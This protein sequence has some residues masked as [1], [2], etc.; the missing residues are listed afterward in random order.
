MSKPILITNFTGQAENPHIGFGVNVG[1]D[2]YTT[3]NV[4]RLSRKMEKKSAALATDLPLFATEDNNGYIYSQLQDGKILKSTDDGV[5]WT[6]LAGNAGTD[7]K[8]LVAWQDYL[9]AFFGTGVDLYGPL[10]GASAWINNWTGFTGGKALQNVVSINHVPFPAPFANAFMY[11]CNGKYIAQVK[12]ITFP[13][14]PAGASNVDWETLN[15]KF[16]MQDYYNAKCLGFLPTSSIAIGVENKLNKSQADIVIWDGSADTSA[17]NIFTIPG[18]TGPVTNLLTRNG[19]MYATTTNEAGVYT[20]NGSSAQLVDRLGLRM[21]NRTSTGVQNTSRVQPTVQVGSADFLGPEM[22]VGICSYPTPVSQPAGTGLYP[23]G[24]W[25]ADIEGKNVYTKFP[26]SHG[27]INAQYTTNYQIGFVK[28][29]SNGKVLVGWQKS[30]TFG[31]DALNASDYISDP[32]TTF[33][34]SEL[35]EVGTRIEPETYNN[36]Q[37]NLIEPLQTSAQLDFY[38]RLSQGDPY[39][40]FRTETPATLGANLGGIITPLPFQQ[41]KYVQFGV[42][43]TTGSGTPTQTPQL[44]S[45]YLK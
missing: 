21:T 39:V 29:I 27:D 3:K 24:V 13:F 6:V 36:I 30:N 5:T 9:W 41:A 28:V 22:L 19:I 40:L 45:I 32:N 34:E 37:F 1:V 11:I 10:S 26:L 14:N 18:A 38:Y 12:V 33:V 17:S 44:V 8:G 35:F 31:I 43:I 2:L 7:G 16:T 25:A 20:V 23:Y 4:A 42:K 15:T